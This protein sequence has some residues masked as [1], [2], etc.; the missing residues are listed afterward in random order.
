MGVL[1]ALAHAVPR[2]GVELLSVCTHD[3]LLGGIAGLVADPRRVGPHVGDQPFR[4]LASAEVDAL[5]EPLS[6][7][8]GSA[9]AHLEF[10]RSLLLQRRGREGRR[11]V[12]AQLAFFDGCN[13]IGGA[14]ERAQDGI[15][16]RVRRNLELLAA[17]RYQIG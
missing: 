3:E 1:R 9:Y 8:H 13:A 11:R 14:V 5:V 7:L 17:M 12:S 6:H 16:G 4:P 2:S 15:G 10:S